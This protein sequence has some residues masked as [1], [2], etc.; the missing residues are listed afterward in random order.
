MPTGDITTNAGTLQAQLEVSGPGG[1]PFLAPLVAMLAAAP[2]GH[3]VKLNTAQATILNSLLTK[4]TG[5]DNLQTSTSG[6]KNSVDGLK[7]SVD[8]L[9]AARIDQILAALNL[10]L[11]QATIAANTTAR[12][13]SIDATL[14]GWNTQIGLLRDYTVALASVNSN[15][16]LNK[17]ATDLVVAAINTLSPTNTPVFT[18]VLLAAANTQYAVTLPIGT[19]RIEFS[20]RNDSSRSDV[21]ADVRWSYVAGEVFGA[22]PGTIPVGSGYSVL[23]RGFTES[24]NVNFT[25]AQILYLSSST[26]NTIV[27]IRRYS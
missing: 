8:A 18:S 9:A 16:T 4:A 5:I 15:L 20:C 3:E 12:A 7:N 13:I 11:A 1:L 25:T 22:S 14:T 17:N 21:S 24:Q 19:E 27:S 6:T 2:D 23:S 10:N 26:A